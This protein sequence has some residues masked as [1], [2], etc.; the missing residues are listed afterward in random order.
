MPRKLKPEKPVHESP[1]K[2]NKNRVLFR[3]DSVSDVSNSSKTRKSQPKE[4]HSGLKVTNHVD[5]DSSPLIPLAKSMPPTLTP[6]MPTLPSVSSF[7][8]QQLPSQKLSGPVIQ[9]SLFPIQKAASESITEIPK[10][11]ESTD[12][13]LD[14]KVGKVLA[15]RVN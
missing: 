14:A 10:K 2:A 13:L 12:T 6:S 15:T 5:S 8:S 9:S 11:V 1:S 4:R 3:I 7:V